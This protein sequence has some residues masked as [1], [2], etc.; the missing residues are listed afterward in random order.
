MRTARV[1][2]A[3]IACFA[4]TAAIAQAQTAP[5]ATPPGPYATTSSEYKLPAAIDPDVSTELATELWARVYRPVDLADKPHP[6]L[7]FLHGNHATC[8]RF[9]G[10]GPGRFDINVQY[11]F[12]GT[13]PEG[14]VVVPSHEGYAYLA[15][16]LASWNYIVVSINANRGVNAAPGTLDDRGNNLRRGRLILKHL[17]RLHEW[18]SGA[19]TP[20]SLGF[21][22]AG[23]LDFAHMGM[24]GHSRGG[25]GVRAA[26]N[27]YR[28]P[29]SPWPARIGPVGF[30]GIFE[31]GPVDGQTSRILNADGT[32]WNVL[33]PMCDGDVFTLQGVRPFDRMLLIRTETPATPKST[34]TVWGTNHNFYNTEWQLSDSPG[35]LGHKRLFDHLLGSADER[36]TA[37]FSVLAF[38]RAHVG[39][40][41][42]S[43]FADLF[44]PQFELPVGL[45]DV[46]RIDRGYTDSPNASVTRTFDDFDRP[47]GFNSSG[48]ANTASNVTVNH[49]GIA[50]HS[51]QQRVA[52]IAWKSPG[53]N[54]FFQSNWTAPGSGQSASGFKTLDFRVARQ[55][56]DSACTKTDS[57]WL[58]ATSFSVRLVGADGSLST[59]IPI[60]NYLT[61][62]GPVGGLVIGVGSSPHPILQTIRIPLAS[63]GSTAIVNNLR[64]VRFTFD[65]TK[66]DEIFIGN[67]RLSTLSA[68]NA[69]TRLAP[70]VVA[71]DDSVVDDTGSKSD[72][73]QVKAI[74]Q[75][76]G[77]NGA[78]DVEIELTSN[79]EF[80][81]QGEL[82]VLR[83]GSQEFTA[84]RY[85]QNGDTGTVIFTL[86]SAEFAQLEDGSTLTVQYGLGHDDPNWRF[87]RLNKGQL[88]K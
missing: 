46:T 3:F 43:T 34:F 82:L 31:I 7:I 61:L 15:E 52:Q 76:S 58:F 38:F 36:T 16:R 40:A 81:P 13:C 12:F 37:L 9:E 85:L 77:I 79:R 33:L 25:E 62:T 65:D 87:G 74:R 50:N 60:S 55:C 1:S 5:D 64:G 10:A 75:T 71:G 24:L 42:D 22:L 27:I 2:L 59:P 39:G 41:T 26:Y 73:N 30:E 17:Q 57:H 86:T 11:T 49:G 56:G 21:S 44:N 78:T 53:S 80:L 18:N 66:S 19:P 45:E 51:S 63:F 29:G 67:I 8:G 48:A 84:S 14:F 23:Q 28:D 72:N 32:S 68:L 35:C 20:P 47:T 4:L 88:A 6:L 83:I 54:T 70:E 69:A